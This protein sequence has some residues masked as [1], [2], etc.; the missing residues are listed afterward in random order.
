MTFSRRM[1]NTIES[2]VD[3]KNFKAAFDVIKDNTSSFYYPSPKIISLLLKAIT[4]KSCCLTF[5]VR[6]ILT[7][8]IER[9]ICHR[10]ITDHAQFRFF[11]LSLKQS[12]C[13]KIAIVPTY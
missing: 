9:E 8:Q 2:S 7:R 13:Q 1:E 6:H 5:L 12:V 11:Y 4:V 10:N 3:D